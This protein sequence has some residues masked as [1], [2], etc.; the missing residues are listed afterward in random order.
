MPRG[1]GGLAGGQK[2]STMKL[3]PNDE[4]AKHAIHT[5]KAP[6]ALGPYSQAIRSGD[7]LF[8][9]GQIALDPLTG[10]LVS[11]GIEPET[12]QVL[13]NIEAVLQAAGLAFASVVKSTIF[14]VDIADFAAVNEIYGAG[15]P[16]DTVPPARSTVQVARL[17]RN[18][19]IEIEV[20]ASF[21]A[22]P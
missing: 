9:S 12:R 1:P 4:P 7:F 17:P 2:G 3:M 8:T 21:S 11:G 5:D 16:A 20:V 14:L 13:A 22:K 6:A 10:N 15:F 19:R 18:A